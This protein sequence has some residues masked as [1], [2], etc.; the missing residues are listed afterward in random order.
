MVSLCHSSPNTFSSHL[1]A[2]IQR[3][4]A[5]ARVWQARIAQAF[6]YLSEPIEQ[7]DLFDGRC[8]GKLYE[9]WAGKCLVQQLEHLV[10]R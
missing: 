3:Q 9:V 4:I 8:T 7:R 5:L 2:E 6:N 1:T 10:G